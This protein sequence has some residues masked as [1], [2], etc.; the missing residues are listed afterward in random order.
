MLIP[1]VEGQRLKRGFRVVTGSMDIATLVKHGEVPYRDAL[2]KTGYQRRPQITRVNSFAAEMRKGQTDVPTSILLNVRD[3]AED[4]LTEDGNDNLFINLKAR[5][6]KLYI[7]DGQHRFLAFKKLFDDESEKWRHHRL[8]FVMMLGAD[9][10]EEINQFYVVNTTAKSVRTDLALDLLKQRA[11]TDGQIMLSLD[12]KGQRWK[13]EGQA[14]VDDLYRN[15]RIWGGRIQLANADRLG[16]IIPSASFITSLKNLLS[17]SPFFMKLNHDQK[18]QIIEAYWTGIKRALREPFDGRPDDY[19]LQKGIGVTAMHEILPTVIEIIRS[20]GGSVLEP[21]AYRDIMGP[22][23]ES[24]SGDNTSGENVSGA[25]FW[26]TAPKGGAAGSFSSSAG[27]RVLFA[28]LRA[29]LP[30]LAVE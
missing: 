16:T 25:E 21:D 11:E 17:L 1:V 20:E 14:I 10:K 3:L 7:V 2:K 23:L 29:L 8:Q 12:Q 28:K 9:I 4:F 18:V 26:L 13:I 30:E 19:A 24:L 6:L 15:S 22:V 27:K 5:S